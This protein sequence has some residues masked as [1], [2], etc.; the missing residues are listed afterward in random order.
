MDWK[1]FW[2][3]FLT[4]KDVYYE[5]ADALDEKMFQDGVMTNMLILARK[6]TE[7]YKVNPDVDTMRLLLSGLPDDE[8]NRMNLYETFLA[9]VAAVQ[10]TVNREAFKDEIM[11]AA[12]RYEMEKFIV[13]TAN[14]IDQV[15]FEEA[16]SGLRE[17]MN[18]FKTA[19]TGIDLTDSAKVIPLIRYQP[20]DKVQSGMPALDNV[21]Y[22]GWG[23]NELA[24]VMAPPGR[25][26]SAFLLNAMYSTMINGSSALYITLELSDRA[27]ARRMYSRIAYA[28]KQQMLDEELLKNSA[29]KFFSLSKARGRVMYYPSRSL[30]VDRIEAILEQMKHQYDFTPDLLIIDYLDL[31]GSRQSDW[32]LDLRQRLRTITDD[33]RSISL[34][35]NIAILTAT[36]ANREALKKKKITEAN[37]SEAFGKVEVADIIMAICQTEEEFKMKRARLSILKNRDNASGAMLELHVDFERMVMMDLEL[38]F[39]LGV[40]EVPAESAAV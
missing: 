1:L 18:K 33:L 32:K 31:L 15:S 23:V 9:S 36:Q 20:T 6:F 34:R 3:V 39:Q 21:L 26:K 22:G 17:S 35:R 11:K 25:G 4:D 28:N 30:T 27:V 10:T 7:K 19:S 12:Q 37:V 16:M 14:T 40:L 38:A 8:K 2:H 5:F 29:N 13:K 24:I